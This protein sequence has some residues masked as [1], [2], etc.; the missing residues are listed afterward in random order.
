MAAL[1]D[2]DVGAWRT[3]RMHP[4]LPGA[5]YFWII[6][7]LFVHNELARGV[8]CR[9]RRAREPASWSMPVISGLLMGRAA[10]AETSWQGLSPVMVHLIVPCRTRSRVAATDCDTQPTVRWRPASTRR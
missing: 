8:R 2:A 9:A 3:R 4:G 6:E 5:F 7:H 10:L 1:P